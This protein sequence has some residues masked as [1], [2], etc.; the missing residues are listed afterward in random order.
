MDFPRELFPCADVRVLGLLK[1][2]FQ[3]LKLLVGEDGSVSPLPSAVELVQELELGPR[4]GAHVH[5][6]HHLVRDGRDE[7]GARAVITCMKK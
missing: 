2:V 7:H 5:I 1:K 6:G 3:S 4:Q